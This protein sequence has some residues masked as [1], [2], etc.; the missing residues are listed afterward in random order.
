[1]VYC[2]QWVAERARSNAGATRWV[3]RSVATGLYLGVEEPPRSAGR[4][5]ATQEETEWDVR[6]DREDPSTLR[7]VLGIALLTMRDLLNTS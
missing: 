4:V 6:P 5:I 7:W 1:M 2:Q 3:L